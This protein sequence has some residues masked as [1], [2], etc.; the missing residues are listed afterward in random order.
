VHTL[1]AYAIKAAGEGANPSYTPSTSPYVAD[2][3]TPAAA[4]EVSQHTGPP[5]PPAAC[6]QLAGLALAPMGAGHILGVACGLFD[7]LAR[8]ASAP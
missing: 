8:E 7:G 1:W 2:F 6:P 4:L 5:A 3:S